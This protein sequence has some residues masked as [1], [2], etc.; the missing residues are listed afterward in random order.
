MT[1]E[2]ATPLNQIDPPAG[3]ACPFKKQCW[4]RE[5]LRWLIPA[6]I[7][8]LASHLTGCVQGHVVWQGWPPGLAV[9]ASWVGQLPL[10]Q[11]SIVTTPPP[12]TQPV[13]PA[14]N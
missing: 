5:L 10:A 12:T 3:F 8:M 1:D 6:L 2:P 13:A 4:T 9:D 11:P 7:A 14:A